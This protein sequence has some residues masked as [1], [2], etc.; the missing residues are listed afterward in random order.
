MSTETLQVVQ[1]IDWNTIH[2]IFSMYG[3]TLLII[4]IALA[5][6]NYLTRNK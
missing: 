3:Y 5:V 1:K 4:F 2:T 6:S